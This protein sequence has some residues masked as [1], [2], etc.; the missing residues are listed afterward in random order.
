MRFYC[1]SETKIILKTHTRMQ[2]M[3]FANVQPGFFTKQIWNCQSRNQTKRDNT[4][5]IAI[6]FS[7]CDNQIQILQQT[8]NTIQTSIG[9]INNNT[10]QTA[11]CPTMHLLMQT[12]VSSLAFDKKQ[13]H[14]SISVPHVRWAEMR[15]WRVLV[16]EPIILHPC[17]PKPNGE[18]SRQIG[19]MHVLFDFRITCPRDP[20]RTN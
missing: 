1:E 3:S 5:I 6:T 12:H 2:A 9:N 14:F 19:G 15:P 11:W 16:P 4:S 13:P 20:N 18:P 7:K 8:I 10:L 17:G